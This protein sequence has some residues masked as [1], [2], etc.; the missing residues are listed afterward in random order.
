M[1][2]NADTVCVF[3]CENVYFEL[4]SHPGQHVSLIKNKVQSQREIAQ[5]ESHRCCL[6]LNSIHTEIAQSEVIFLHYS[7]SLASF[8]VHIKK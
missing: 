3:D 5:T 1:V 6:L 7:Q 2:G 8:L 4:F